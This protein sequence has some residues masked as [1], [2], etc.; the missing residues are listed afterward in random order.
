M[1]V[2]QMLL[3]VYAA[4]SIAVSRVRTRREAGF[5]HVENDKFRCEVDAL[6]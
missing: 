2:F 6:R 1:R 5:E 4:A 3:Q